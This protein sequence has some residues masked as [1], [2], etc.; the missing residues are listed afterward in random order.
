[1]LKKGQRKIFTLTA[2]NDI[3]GM[4]SLGKLYPQIISVKY[5]NFLFFRH[6]LLLAFK[7]KYSTFR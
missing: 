7:I 2:I 4:I 1:M 3:I 5:F 6:Q